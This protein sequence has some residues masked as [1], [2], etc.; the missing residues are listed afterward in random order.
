MVTSDQDADRALRL[1][2]EE[3]EPDRAAMEGEIYRIE[4]YVEFALQYQRLEGGHKD[5]VFAHY[6]LESIVKKP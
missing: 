1:L 6:S 4:Q 2:L 5:L 3:E